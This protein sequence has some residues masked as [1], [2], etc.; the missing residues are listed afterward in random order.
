MVNL[1]SSY[2]IVRQAF[3]TTELT[4]LPAVVSS[5]CRLTLKN[6]CKT[7]LAQNGKRPQLRSFCGS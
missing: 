4:F 6:G 5:I 2:R 1:V 3:D 7:C